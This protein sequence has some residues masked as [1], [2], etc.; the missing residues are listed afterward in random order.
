MY[1][2]FHLKVAIALRGLF[3]SICGFLGSQVWATFQSV[4]FP[5]YLFFIE[6]YKTGR[7]FSPTIIWEHSSW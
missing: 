1:F 7:P 6:G 4:I 5:V 3:C 2:I